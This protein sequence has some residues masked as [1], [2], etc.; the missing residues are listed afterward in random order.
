MNIL[1]LGSGGREHALA[2][3]IAASPHC[4]KLI[5]VPGNAGTALI[6]KNISLDPND[7]PAIK[8]LVVSEGVELVVVGPEAPL[9]A[10]IVDFFSADEE[11][12]TIPIIGPS[13]AGAQLEGSKAFAK[14]FMLRHHIPTATYTS[15]TKD[16]LNEIS[17]SADQFQSTGNLGD[18]K[19]AIGA[20]TKDGGIILDIHRKRFAPL[21]KKWWMEIQK[22]DKTEKPE[23]ET[24]DEMAQYIK[25]ITQPKK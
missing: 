10:G 7:F 12:K 24:Q 21:G 8:A 3:K 4:T 2:D 18:L 9:V 19:P 20:K 11:L 6:G 13:A 16:K 17:K 22:G 1:I 15:F 14:E 5:I 25:E 23:F